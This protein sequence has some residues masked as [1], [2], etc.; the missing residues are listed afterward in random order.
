MRNIQRMATKLFVPTDEDILHS[1]T[2]TTGILE[3]RFQIKGTLFRF[4]D[5]GGFCG[6]DLALFEAKCYIGGQRQ[7]R[8]R[9]WVQAFAGVTVLLFVAALNEYDLMLAEDEE[10]VSLSF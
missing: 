7:E 3:T 5:V 6:T 4:V 9:K 1:R 10:T 2:M 8:R